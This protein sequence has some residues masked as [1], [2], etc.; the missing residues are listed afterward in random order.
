MQ[1][2]E[3][4]S[5]ID[6]HPTMRD[7]ILSVRSLTESNDLG[8][9]RRGSVGR[10]NARCKSNEVAQRPHHVILR[11]IHP[12]PVFGGY[13]LFHLH[14]TPTF[15]TRIDMTAQPEAVNL[16]FQYGVDISRSDMCFTPTPTPCLETA[17]R[18]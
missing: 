4:A 10:S 1:L 3:S 15:S 9:V 8:Y 18:K 16:G 5:S 13:E 11:V 14:Y 2:T 7:R 6:Q 17:R 12:R